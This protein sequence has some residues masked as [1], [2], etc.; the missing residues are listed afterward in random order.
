MEK[1]EAVAIDGASETVRA[2]LMLMFDLQPWGTPDVSF[3]L[4]DMKSWQDRSAEMGRQLKAYREAK[5]PIVAL[6]EGVPKAMHAIIKDVDAAFLFGDAC[7]MSSTDIPI[8]CMEWEPFPDYGQ[9]FPH[10]PKQ[11]AVLHLSD[12][13]A[14]EAYA[15]DVLRGA[16]AHRLTILA[17]AEEK[18]KYPLEL[19]SFCVQEVPAGA[20]SFAVMSFHVEQAAPGI[21]MA[22]LSAAARLQRVA[23]HGKS[24]VSAALG[25]TFFFPES[26]RELDA[27]IQLT[28]RYPQ[29]LRP[30]IGRAHV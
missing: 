5:V 4:L 11:E 9:C 19:R 21:E 17:D 1:K 30:K 3:A 18:S 14:P 28:C 26:A 25:D 6:F 10:G 8:P 15:K 13:F 20:P 22:M 23:L 2:Q 27:H 7:S 24:K 29:R 16:I 12:A